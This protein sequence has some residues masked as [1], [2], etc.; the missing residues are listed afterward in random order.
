MRFDR[1]RDK[2]RG[3][4]RDGRTHAENGRD[5]FQE[6]HERGKDCDYHGYICARYLSQPLQWEQNELKTDAKIDMLHQS[7]LFG[8]P[9][10][11]ARQPVDNMSEEEDVEMSLVSFRQ[12]FAFFIYS[13]PS[14]RLW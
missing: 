3:L 13:Q 6:A 11:M 12:Q 8:S 10:K 7:G 4:A 14:G 5:V 9:V 2:R 1:G